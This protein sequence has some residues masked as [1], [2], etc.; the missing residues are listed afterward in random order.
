[1]IGNGNGAA[2]SAPKP[3]FNAAV[4]STLHGAL[5]ISNERGTEYGDTWAL[6]NQHTPFLDAVL[7]ELRH[8]DPCDWTN[9]EKRLIVIAAL[10]DV[11]IS[12]LLGGY[13]ADT[14]DDLIN[15]VAALRAWMAEYP[16]GESKEPA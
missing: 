4:D 2:Q 13:K 12:R 16:N 7:N 9:E 15:Y 5:E 8:P 10:C 11:K 14:L 1:M 3:A 6:E